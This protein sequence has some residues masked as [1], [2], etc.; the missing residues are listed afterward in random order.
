MRRPRQRGCAR[1]RGEALPARAEA[2]ARYLPMRGLCAG[3]DGSGRWQVVQI[4][5]D[6]E[7]TAACV[8]KAVSARV[9]PRV[10]TALL[11]DGRR[12]TDDEL[13]Y[14]HA[15]H[16]TSSEH[17]RAAVAFVR[18]A[19]QQGAATATPAR[20]QPL[21]NTA[22]ARRPVN[23]Q[24]AESAEGGSSS[25]ST[26]PPVLRGSPDALVSQ[27][28]S[29]SLPSGQV[30]LLMA[31][32]IAAEG[33]N[34]PK[35]GRKRTVRRE[36]KGALGKRKGGSQGQEVCARASTAA[37]AE[38]GA[39]DGEQHGAGGDEAE[40][41][42]G[43]LFCTSSQPLDADS[44]VE[45]LRSLH[46]DNASCISH[47]H[48]IALRE[49]RLGRLEHTL[50]DKVVDMLRDYGLSPDS[51]YSHQ[52][53]AVN[54]VLRGEHLVV[55]TPTASG[56]SLCFNIPVLEAVMHPNQQGVDATTAARALYIYPTKSLAQDQLRA[57]H[58]LSSRWLTTGKAA[59]LDG[60]LCARRASS[61]LVMRAAGQVPASYARGGPVT[62]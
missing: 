58:K 18:D 17:P 42:L 30:D 39:A 3:D 61:S 48:R 38:R 13:L 35:A 26:A 2:S 43:H 62:R 34:G 22:A 51:L 16:A 14:P 23:R 9:A 25:T 28:A 20:S 31:A 21:C 37:G 54:A 15:A 4:A 59:V 7:S 52:A 1:S 33:R 36:T 46:P 27:A 60:Q 40:H 11:L 19:A 56:K 29:P 50:Q 44:F 41:G 5:V 32:A 49:A 24:A 55:T 8:R 53:E 47:V 6:G 57:L 12:C 10:C 45:H